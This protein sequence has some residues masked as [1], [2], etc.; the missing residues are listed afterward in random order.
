MSE[1]TLYKV[2]PEFAA[3]AHISRDGYE[4]MYRRSVE[5]GVLLGG[6]G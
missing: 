1:P 2:D 6:A 5:T 4:E 3:N